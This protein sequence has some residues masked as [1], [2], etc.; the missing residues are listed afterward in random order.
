MRAYLLEGV[1]Y[2]PS[3]DH[4]VDGEKFVNDDEIIIG[5]SLAE[6]LKLDSSE[7]LILVPLDGFIGDVK[8]LKYYK[9]IFRRLLPL[10][11]MNMIETL[12]MLVSIQLKKYLI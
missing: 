11:W 9:L 2:L 8:N 5:S 3:F 6:S 4:L 7:A 1:N 10:G 12:L